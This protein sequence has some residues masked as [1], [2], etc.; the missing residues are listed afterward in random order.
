MEGWARMGRP[1]IVNTDGAGT[2]RVISAN[3]ERR[4]AGCS[5]PCLVVASVLNAVVTGNVR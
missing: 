2:A 3:D 4:E 5:M 1:A